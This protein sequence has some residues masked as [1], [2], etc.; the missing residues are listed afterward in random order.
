MRTLT[1]LLFTSLTIVACELHRP[2]AP[3]IPVADPSRAAAADVFNARYARSRFSR[4]HVQGTTAGP[5]C[6]VLFVRTAILLE[7]S[8]VESI[9]YGAGAYD[10]YDGGVQQFYRDRKFRGVV[11]KDPSLRVWTY[12][13]VQVPEA[14]QLAPCGRR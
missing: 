5:Q 2:P 7:E 8:M 1:T 4:W 10:V 6:D 3:Q 12:G 13:D 14:E 11:Y 9:H